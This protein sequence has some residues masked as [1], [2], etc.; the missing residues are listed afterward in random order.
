MAAQS[1]AGKISA[2]LKGRY[3]PFFQTGLLITATLMLTA[4]GSGGAG[5]TQTAPP[6]PDG[7][8]GTLT[9][10]PATAGNTLPIVIDAGPGRNEINVGYV[11]V[12]LCTPGASGAAPACQTIDHVQLDTGS[13]GLRLLKSALYSNLNLPSVTSA[14]GQAIGEC[15]TFA[16]GVNWGSVRLADIYLG[17]EVAKSVPFQEIGDQPGGASGVPADCSATG[18]I[19]DSQLSLGSNGILGVGLLVNDCDTCLTQAVPASYYTCSAAGCTNSTVTAAQ[20]VQNPV[21]RFSQDNNGVLLKLPAV[22]TAGTAIPV[23][24]SLIFGIGTQTNNAMNGATVYTTDAYGNFITT[25]NNAK[26]SFSYIDSGSNAI[27]FTDTSI[28]LCTVNT[29]VYC[30][31]TSPLLLSASNSS[32]SG[33][34]SATVDFNIINLDQLSSNTVAADIGGTSVYG[35]F[36]WGLPFF[37]G[38]SVFTAISGKKTPAGFGPYYAY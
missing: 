2:Y 11:S 24:G 10:P 15:A 13:Y 33:T 7:V 25:F 20:V 1:A 30:P 23:T 32:A 4:C 27:F 29:W 31:P 9:S 37:Y 14:G 26:L 16:I 6:N 18:A 36:A 35:Q 22:S 19:Q 12:T 17:G 28:P 38:R 21:A 5:S 3:I 34:P 8:S